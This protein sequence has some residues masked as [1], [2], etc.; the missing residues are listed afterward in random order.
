VP[1]EL[2]PR[3]REEASREVRPGF[4]LPD[5]ELRWRFSR[6]SGPGGQGVNTADSRV[7]LRFDVARSHAVPE[8]L[9]A[10]ALARLDGRLVDGVLVVTASEQRA[11]LR[12]REAALGRLVNLL[13][14]ATAP[15]PRN[16]RPTRPSKGSVE[17]RLAAK[18]QRSDTK[19][20]R[21][22]GD[23]DSDR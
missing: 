10:R 7:E 19:R 1:D 13:R 14:D 3:T 12:N 6:S 22:A 23:P 20:T 2:S 15:P 16:R 4:V 21:R 11:Q 5:G 9:R 18:R 17:R 8:P